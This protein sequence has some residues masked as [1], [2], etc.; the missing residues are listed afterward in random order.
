V[1]VAFLAER[2]RSET[3]PMGIAGGDAG[4]CGELI[5]DGKPVN[6]KSQHHIGPGGTVLIRTPAGGGY[7]P[8]E[9]RDKKRSAADRAE[10]YVSE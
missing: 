5:I 7:G 2:T 8:S 4:A 10:G 3:A 6:P 9:R 1:T